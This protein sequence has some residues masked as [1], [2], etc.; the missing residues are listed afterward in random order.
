[1]FTDG[2]RIF[3]ELNHQLI[4]DEGHRNP[5]TVLNS[6]LACGITHIIE[7]RRSRLLFGIAQQV[8]MGYSVF[9]T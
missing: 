7:S 9:I 3:A 2:G 1:M 5:M 8:K 6:L 4:H